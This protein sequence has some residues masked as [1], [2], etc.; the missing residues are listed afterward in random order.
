MA[1]SDLAQWRHH[2]QVV[3]VSVQQTATNFG[4]AKGLQRRV[5]RMQDAAIC[6]AQLHKATFEQ[7]DDP[8]HTRE[9]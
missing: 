4:V 7:R 5:Q 8:V 2:I 6:A 3:A 1:R 9:N